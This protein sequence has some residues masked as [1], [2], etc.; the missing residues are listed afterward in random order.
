[1]IFT[2]RKVTVNND[3]AS[4]DKNI[5]LFRGDREV[6]I[7]FT[8]IYNV[9]KYRKNDG[10]NLIED[11]NATYGQ[12]VI[13]NDATT[14]PILSN[15][16]PTENG[17]V[18]FK[19]TKEMID[20]IPEVGTYDFQ[21]RLFD[22][23]QTSRIT[24]PIVD[25]GIIIKE[26]LSVEETSSNE[27]GVATVNSA[28]I[29]TSIPLEV[30]DED[31]KY[32]ETTWADKMLITDVR[33]NKIEQ[34]ITGVNQKAVNAVDNMPTA[35]SQLTNDSGYITEIPE[36]YITE[37]E[38]TSKGYATTG[39]IPTNV[40]QLVNDSDYTTKKYVDDNLPHYNETL[41]FEITGKTNF[42]FLM[43]NAYFN[44]NALNLDETKQY[45]L[46]VKDLTQEQIFEFVYDKETDALIDEAS[47]TYVYNHK[48][49]DGTNF[50]ED[51]NSAVLTIGITPYSTDIPD[52]ISVKIYE[53]DKVELDNNC[54]SDNVS[55]K[56]SLTVG[57][58]IG[59]IGL[60]SGKVDISGQIFTGTVEA[61]IVK[62]TSYFYT[63]TLVNEGDLNSYY[64]RL[65]LGYFNHNY[66]EFHDY[67]GDFRFYQNTGGTST[68]GVMI[69][70]IT[71]KYSNFVGQL[72][73]AGTRV[74]S[75]NNK[76]SAAE[77]GITVPTTTSDLI[78]D[79]DFTTNAYVNEQISTVELTPGPQGPKGDTGEQGP[80][81]A[82]G[83]TPIKGVDYFDG[84][85]GEQGPKGDT[86]EQGVQG[87]KGE[88]G[89]QGP[90]GEVGPQGPKGDDGL[91]TSISVNGTTYTQVSGLISLPN[92]PSVPTSLPANGGNADTIDNY[93][94][95]SGT[96]AQFDAVGAKDSNTI[97]L[98]KEG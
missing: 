64:H 59:D 50:I 60:Y 21:I 57:T 82:D 24:T 85:K 66:W 94:I 86:G 34:G 48:S 96:Q 81:G 28:V 68:T 88:Q 93:H 17:I 56:N 62:A 13:Q 83:Y 6:E 69:A 19:F 71:S 29:S 51:E 75:P 41:M 43:S 23:T 8:V 49:Y 32:I 36:E 3:T 18:I 73:E 14:N 89:I 76:P 65:N 35:T 40:S 58:R 22:D 31:G 9:F 5:V 16:T 46:K 37:T 79:S 78:N 97:Y 2:E 15:I 87:P 55:I 11:V 25:N 26:P 44:V 70:N 12:L 52:D 63:P 84:A 27:V 92:Y 7:R 1:M 30:F 74:Y 38:L 45:I 91:T 42:E 39:Q 47:S 90:Q 80:A 61:P 10:I 67:G 72:R 98:V 53:I 33:L 77:L 95:W 54:L 4:I 20:E